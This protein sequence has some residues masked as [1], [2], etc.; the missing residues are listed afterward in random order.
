MFWQ[1]EANVQKRA[2]PITYGA[3][4]STNG[5]SFFLPAYSDVYRTLS[6][7]REKTCEVT[8]FRRYRTIIQ[9]KAMKSKCEYLFCEPR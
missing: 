4:R 8:S 2:R 5:G 7:E 3:P 6:W 1:M 9:Q